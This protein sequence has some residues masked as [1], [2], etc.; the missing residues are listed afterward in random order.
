MLSVYT[1]GLQSDSA[2]V[3]DRLCAGTLQQI[4]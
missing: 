4:L 2:P 3:A 1:P